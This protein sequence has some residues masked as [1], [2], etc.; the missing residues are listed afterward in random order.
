[1]LSASFNLMFIARVKCWN[2]FAAITGFYDFE[3][4]QAHEFSKRSC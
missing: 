3:C 4:E 1:M 2:G